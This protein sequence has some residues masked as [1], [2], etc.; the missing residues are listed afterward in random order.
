MKLSVWVPSSEIQNKRKEL[1]QIARDIAAQQ[2]EVHSKEQK[3]DKWLELLRSSECHF[4]R[5]VMVKMHNEGDGEHSEK[6][7]DLLEEDY[8]VTVPEENI[9]PESI[10]AGDGLKSRLRS[11]K[12]LKYPK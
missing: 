6:A 8:E 2:A 12:A 10:L 3:Y 1:I 7:S 9:Q 5:R 4:H 11:R